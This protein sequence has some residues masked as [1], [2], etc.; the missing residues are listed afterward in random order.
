MPT[1]SCVG[2]AVAP[3]TRDVAEPGAVPRQPH[4]RRPRRAAA[5]AQR[6]PH[7]RH[8]A[9]GADEA[10][11]HVA[12]R[13]PAG[14]DPDRDDVGA[15]ARR[16][17]ADRRVGP[18]QQ[19]GREGRP[20]KQRPALG[21]QRLP[22]A[23]REARQ[24]RRQR[25]DD[26]DARRL[27]AQQQR[28]RAAGPVAA[29]APPR[30][31]RR[32]RDEPDEHRLDDDD[33]P[34]VRPAQEVPAVDLAHRRQDAREDREPERGAGDRRERPRPRTEGDAAAQRHERQGDDAAEPQP[35]G[36]HVHALVQQRPERRERERMTGQRVRQQHDRAAAE[37]EPL[38]QG[39]APARGDERDADQHDRDRAHE[40]RHARRARG[41]Q[42]E[43]DRAAGPGAR[44]RQ[45]ALGGRE[46]DHR[47][48]DGRRAAQ[49][50]DVL[51]GDPLAAAQQR[52]QHEAAEEDR[53]GD[54]AEPAAQD[55]DGAIGR[56]VLGAAAAAGPRE[57]LDPRRR[58][59]VR[60]RHA[61]VERSRD[62][63]PVVAEDAPAHL[64]DAAAQ[65][66]AR[67]HG[68]RAPAVGAAHGA[69]GHGPPAG[70]GDPDARAAGNRR[71][72]ER[73]A[74]RP[75]RTV[76]HDPRLRRCSDQQRMCPGG[77]RPGAH[78]GTERD[79]RT[80]QGTARRHVGRAPTSSPGSARRTSC[81]SPS[82]RSSS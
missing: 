61:E 24:P 17:E 7:R 23:L 66:R 45:D 28:P 37:V 55:P 40:A 25:D 53:R 65:R 20:R 79:G 41:Q 36:E 33:L 49:D 44:R 11:A 27:G 69:H 76:R 67:R 68:D 56:G 9:A 15:R 18:R 14:R 60:A 57:P 29:R 78:E 71:L 72:R 30:V 38:A 3:S 50:R 10:H 1:A 8:G 74:D 19:R 48:G 35:G 51:A 6:R 43:V 5:A 64:V 81:A 22:A 70:P 16:E 73:D 77:R 63:M 47:P 31:A 58:R 75:R 34:V 26:H 46:D 21:G 42:P 32:E 12:R 62:E 13:P 80:E 82:G 4:R 2:G 54:D 52:E 59:A 39:R